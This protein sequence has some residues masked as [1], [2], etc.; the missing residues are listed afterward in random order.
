MK[1][2]NHLNSIRH[3]F[4]VFFALL[5]FISANNCSSF[6]A[7]ETSP[8]LISGGQLVDSLGLN[9]VSISTVD[10]DSLS[11][12]SLNK[13]A[14]EEWSLDNY[15][16]ALKLMMLAYEKAKIIQDELKL[17]PI[18]NNLGLIHWRLGNNSDAIDCYQEAS[19]LASKHKLTRLW[20]L[21]QT[22]LS[23]INKEQSNFDIAF[24]YNEKAIEVFKKTQNHRDLG[25]ALNNQGQIHKNMQNYN[26]ARKYYLEAIQ[27]YQKVNYKDGLSAT[28][29]NLSDIFLKQEKKDS[30]LYSIK[31]SLKLGFESKSKIRISEAYQK[32]AEVFEHFNLLDS[33]LKYY[34]QYLTYYSELQLAN[35]SNIL[36]L[37]QAEMGAEVKKLQIENL[38]K[39]QFLVKSRIQL[40]SAILFIVILIS[41]FII[42]RY[43]SNIR[44]K[45]RKLEMELLTSKTILEIKE[46]ELKAYILDLSKKNEI[47]SKLQ[48]RF[49]ETHKYEKE[50]GIEFTSLLEQKIL[51][52]AD[53]EIFK[54]KFRAI[55]PEF[56][57]QI[58]QLRISLTEA[59]IRLLVLISLKLSAKEMAQT[60]GISPQS[61][62][63][64]KMRLKKKIIDE[65][66]D[67]VENFA[68]YLV[69]VA[70]KPKF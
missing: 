6:S 41:S 38:K 53:W 36:A 24:S 39:E 21:T 15:Q 44:F 29:Y 69:K 49:S 66:F 67:S 11:I 34:K 52:E 26:L 42:Y 40:F 9:P 12:D 16:S 64:C 58:K 2:T 32:T 51:T 59:E 60:L 20:G 56:F 4:A 62:R 17:A 54:S 28:Y 3:L 23:L 70:N 68:E 1:K 13:V 57:S 5:I 37:Y 48:N 22:N 55:Y 33:A 45:K 65:P 27:N 25:I 61:V 18:L 63:V 30:A 50:I 14:M 19:K 8:S 7:E 10:K 43:F 46:Q 47:V 31:N 35:K